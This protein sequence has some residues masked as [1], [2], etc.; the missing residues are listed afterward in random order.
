MSSSDE[1]SPRERSSTWR[2]KLVGTLIWLVVGVGLIAFIVSPWAPTLQK[3]LAVFQSSHRYVSVSQATKTAQIRF[4]VTTPSGTPTMD[5]HGPQLWAIGD[6][7]YWANYRYHELSGYWVSW[8]G[9]P[10]QWVIGARNA[11]WIV[12]TQPHLHSIIVLMPYLQGA[13]RYGMVGVVESI[14]THGGLTT[15]HASL[16]NWSNHG[17]G[18]D[19]ESEDDFNSGAGVYFIWHP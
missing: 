6:C 3:S 5:H 14:A 2:L 4:V 16:M 8:P 9:Y 7:T 12:A 10:D 15:V 18:W 11:G 13:G 1:R 17:G 19:R